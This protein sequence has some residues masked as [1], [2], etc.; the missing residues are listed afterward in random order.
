VN[1]TWFVFASMSFEASFDT[2]PHAPQQ[3]MVNTEN[4]SHR[5]VASS[6]ARLTL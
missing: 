2:A 6:D 3:P 5:G 4:T 1:K